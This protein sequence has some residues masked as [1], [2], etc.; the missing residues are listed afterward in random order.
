MLQPLT[1]TTV[2]YHYIDA[3]SARTVV[4]FAVGGD[5]AGAMTRIDAVKFA[6][7]YNAHAHTT[8]IQAALTRFQSYPG[9]WL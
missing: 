3:I 5:R 7:T 1:S 8:D 9:I 2:L 6:Q 4:F